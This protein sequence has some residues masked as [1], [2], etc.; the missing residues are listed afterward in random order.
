MQVSQEEFFCDCRLYAITT[1][2]P[3]ILGGILNSTIEILFAEF[4]GRQL[5]GGGGPSDIV[6]YEVK[7][8][9]T[10]NPKTLTK[11]LISP[12]ANSLK[13]GKT[14][15]NKIKSFNSIAG[16]WLKTSLTPG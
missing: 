1:S 6:T 2:E 15:S 4:L 3:I 14:D 9:L 13:G 16:I 8:L 10:I 7:H 12:E 5:G 11:P